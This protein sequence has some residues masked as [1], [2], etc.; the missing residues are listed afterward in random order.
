MSESQRKKT[1]YATLALLAVAFVTAVMASNAFLGG[2]RLDLTENKLYTLSAGTTSMLEGI[3]EPINLYFF[4]SDRET[5]DI[6]YLRA[7]ATRVREILDE[8]A[9]AADG[10]LKLNVIDPLPFSEDEDRAALYGLQDLNAAALGESIYFG[11]AGTNGV[12]DQAIIEVF[13]PAKE[14]SLEYDLARLIYSLAN[15]KKIVVGLLSGAQLAGGFDPQTQQP[16]RPWVVYQQARQ[17]FDVRSL[18]SSFDR[19]D[20]EI[21]LLWIVHP[22][23]L[24][25][26][27]LYAIDQFVLGGGRALI[28]VDP[29]AEFATTPA[30]PG[31]FSGPS[32]SDLARLFEAW[33]VD[34][35]PSQVVVDDFYALSVGGIGRR[36]IRHIGLLGLDESA[37]EESE[38]ISA[39]LSSLNLGIAGYLAPADDAAASFNPLFR[40]SADAALL[41]NVRFQFLQ[42][43]DELLDDFAPSGETYVLAARLEGSLSTAFPDGPPTDDAADGAEHLSSTDS[44][45]VVI[46]ADADVL[47]DRL[48]VSTQRSL[49]G[50]EVSTAFANNGD[51]LVNALANLAGSADLIGLK[52]RQSFSRPF[53]RVEDLRR[54]AD[55]QFRETE[56]RL[57]GRLAELERRLGELQAARSDTSSLLMSED[58]QAELRRFQEEQLQVRRELRAVQRNLDSS[59]ERLGIVLKI[60]NIIVLPVLLVGAVLLFALIGRRRIVR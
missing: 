33:G 27:T 16:A 55:A 54:D 59:I 17:L 47:S 38:L 56:Q 51:F 6:Q 53:D 52:S 44:G 7:Y 22:Q 21:G 26:Q 24:D 43:P 25:E 49:F 9:A 14:A 39:G 31:G 37:M 11:L 13:D 29:M 34:Y 58:Q 30:G 15:P 35:D 2:L 42:S 40:S 48:W 36:T 8:F 18:P 60:V 41:P 19:I 57:Q 46:V 10:K 20:D 45:N 28:F 5:G 23:D 1:A 3:D 32:S 50:Q 12:G 4:F